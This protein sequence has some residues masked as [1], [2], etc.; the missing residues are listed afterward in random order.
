MPSRYSHGRKTR[1][2]VRSMR[3]SDPPATYSCRPPF[4]STPRPPSSA[5]RERCPQALV[6]KGLSTMETRCGRTRLS[7][8]RRGPCGRSGGAVR[9]ALPTRLRPAR[10]VHA[11]SAW[12]VRAGA[13]RCGVRTLKRPEGR[14]PGRARL[15]PAR[16]HTVRT[17][18]RRGEDTAPYQPVTPPPAPRTGAA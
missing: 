9:T 17:P 12:A 13:T 14:A 5:H 4:T 18:R 7:P 1:K 15:A 16:R 10:G 6:E 11:A 3:Q 8:A 2:S